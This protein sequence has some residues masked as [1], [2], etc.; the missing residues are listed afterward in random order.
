MQWRDAS[1]PCC[2]LRVER[3]AGEQMPYT[4]VL[5]DRDAARVPRAV[6]IDPSDSHA[7]DVKTA[8]GFPLGRPRQATDAWV[9]LLNAA[10]FSIYTTLL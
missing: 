7:E 9:K 8:R 2:R 3:E 5:T 6:P 10:A 4:Y 1:K